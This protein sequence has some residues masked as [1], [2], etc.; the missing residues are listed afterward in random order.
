MR[1]AFDVA[2][3]HG[4]N[5]EVSAHCEMGPETVCVVGYGKDKVVL[6]QIKTRIKRL[7][8]ESI[9]AD[10]N[11]RQCV[12]G[13]NQGEVLILQFRASTGWSV[14]VAGPGR[15]GQSWYQAA[16]KNYDE[17]HAGLLQYAENF[18]GVKWEC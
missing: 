5:T 8:C 6:D 16:W 2:V 7:V 18:D 15:E 13:T 10:R 11:H 9:R 4:A 12:V 3:R 1:I 14:A 17:A